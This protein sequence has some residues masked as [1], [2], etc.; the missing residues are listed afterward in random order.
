MAVLDRTELL[1]H[2]LYV[3]MSAAEAAAL[4][5]SRGIRYIQEM[6]PLRLHANRAMELIRAPAAWANN[7]GTG[8]AGRGVRIGIIDT[9]IDQNHPAFQDNSATVPDGFPKCQGDDCNYTNRKVIVA[10]SYVNLLNFQFGTNPVDTRPDD[11]TPRDR[12][13]HG[14]AAAMIAAGVPVTTAGVTL[15]GVA[16]RAFLGNYKV[17]G[18]PGVN[19]VTY[20]NVVVRA[21]EDALRD[22]MDI[23]TLNLGFSAEF[24][25]GDRVCGSGGNQIC[26]LQADAVENAARQQMLITVSAGN[27][28]ESGPNYPTLATINSPGTAPSALTVGATVNGHIWYNT[29]RVEGGNIAAA[30]RTVNIRLGDGPR[31][32]TPLSAPLRDIRAV[33]SDATG[34]TPLANGS[35]TGTM[36]II[37]RGGDCTRA[38]KADNAQRA[39]AVAMLF[40][41]LDRQAVGPFSGF[42]A[43]GIPTAIVGFASARDLRAA[44]TAGQAL[45]GTIDPGWREV[46]ASS[47]EMAGFSSRGPSISNLNTGLA[48]LKPEVTA[49]GTDLLMATQTFDP[50]GGMYDASGYVSAEGTSFSSPMAAGVAALV[51]QRNPAFNAQQMKSAVVNTAAGGLRDFD[52]NNRP[53]DAPVVSAGAGQVDANAAVRTNLLADPTVISFGI[54]RQNTTVPSRGL[55]LENTGSAPLSIRI[56]VQPGLVRGARLTVAPSN[57]SLSPGRSTQVSVQLEGVLPPAGNYD[58]VIVVNGGAVPLRIP[59]LYLVGDGVP[60]NTMALRGGS[61]DARPGDSRRVSVKVVDQFGVPVL[62]AAVRASVVSGGGRIIE[63]N[64]ATDEY[65]I[66]EGRVE[67]GSTLGSQVFRVRVGNLDQDL[68]AQVAP[69]PALRGDGVVNAAS[70]RGG[71]GFAPGSYLSLYGSSLAPF[72][73]VASTATLP[74]A[75]ADVSVSFDDEATRLSVPGRIAFVSATQVNVQVPWEC[76]G[77]SS[78]RMKISRGEYSTALVDLPIAAADPGI[79][80]YTEAASGRLL[81]AALDQRNA[82]VG[83]A[84][85]ARRGEIVQL[86]L[87][88][89]GEVSE[90]QQSGVPAPADRLVNTSAVPA[91]TIG[92]RNAPVIFSG[93]APGF[94][95]LYQVNVRVAEDTPTGEEVPVVVRMGNVASPVARIPVQ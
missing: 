77:L 87:N 62:R 45:T 4:R 39:G 32:A 28:G 8:E 24:A 15:S 12:V 82:L 25:A 30:L 92:E 81:A 9:G 47:L 31:P 1:V 55:V 70:Q 44:L 51:K 52:N 23:V 36:V 57:F 42:S 72:L 79:F 3:R 43:T 35:L 20:P 46:T 27:D 65:G 18:S 2:A 69:G 95:G 5:G 59:F 88:G 37:D 38:F 10:R 89:L 50:N 19:D 80:Q 90:A 26:D 49:I 54:L 76:R 17:F 93:L 67:A 58:G 40:A 14:T 22:G 33:S 60:F 75:L 78:V 66:A 86:F 41:L 91:I 16:P 56:E 61:F 48:P 21:L 85:A 6:A 94:V 64:T 63:F 73:K 53:L 68:F 7:G 11:I 83:S 71:R 13:G 84:N 34:C 74:L 29:L